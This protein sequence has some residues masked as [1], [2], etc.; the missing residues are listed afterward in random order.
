MGFKLLVIFPYSKA[1]KRFNEIWESQNICLK[2]KRVEG[3]VRK[4]V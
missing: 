2:R 1:K 4:T 3:T